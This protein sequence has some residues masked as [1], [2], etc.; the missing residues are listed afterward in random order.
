[1]KALLRP[2]TLA[3]LAVALAIFVAATIADRRES[4]IHLQLR[5][6]A[7][8]CRATIE[9]GASLEL[10]SPG[11]A[12]QI[13]LW[14]IAWIAIL[15]LI[16]TRFAGVDPPAASRHASLRSRRCSSGGICC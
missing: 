1:L 5:C 12:A 10:T 9:G 3:T 15:R 7:D 14:S 11:L 2:P 8:S 6:E 16:I 13:V 4:T